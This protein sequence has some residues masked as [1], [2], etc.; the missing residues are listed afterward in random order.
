MRTAY[1][2]VDDELGLLLGLEQAARRVA[3]AKEALCPDVL[4]FA[5]PNLAKP[6]PTGA[7]GIAEHLIIP[8]PR[9]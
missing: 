5:D 9:N 2:E 3:D 8:C 6:V 1:A 7:W 4:A